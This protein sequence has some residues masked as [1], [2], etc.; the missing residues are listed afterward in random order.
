MSGRFGGSLEHRSGELFECEAF[1]AISMSLL[2]SYFDLYK[3][4]APPLMSKREAYRHYVTL[5]HN[6]RSTPRFLHVSLTSTKR[7]EGSTA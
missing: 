6:Q 4:D 3:F 5:T 7:K 1:L 2:G